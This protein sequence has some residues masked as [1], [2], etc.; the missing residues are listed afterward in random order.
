MWEI[1][2]A[3]YENICGTKL[4]DN[5]RT[6]ALLRML[7]TDL[8]ELVSSQAG[9]EDSFEHMRRYVL[10]QVGRRSGIDAPPPKRQRKQTQKAPH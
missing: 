3:E 1:E 8:Q 10:D 2:V 9:I 5:I 6:Q 4:D 7:P